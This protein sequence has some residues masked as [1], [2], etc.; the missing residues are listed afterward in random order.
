MTINFND[1][2]T[3]A[4]FNDINEGDCFLYNGS[5]YIMAHDEDRDAEYF[6]V[7]LANGEVRDFDNYATV[8]A[9]TAEV[10]FRELK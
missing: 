9:L 1:K 8:Q 3:N 2:N 5:F 4:T 7:N 10:S 6:G